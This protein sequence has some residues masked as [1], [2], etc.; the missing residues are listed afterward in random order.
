[1]PRYRALVAEW[2][3]R[4]PA[5]WL[6]AAALRYRPLAAEAP[7]ASQAPTVAALRAAF[8]GGKL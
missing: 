4:P 3:A 5:H 8:P 1:M 2:R 7:A 6:I